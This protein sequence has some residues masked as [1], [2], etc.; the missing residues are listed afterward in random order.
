V[1]YDTEALIQ[2]AVDNLKN[3]TPEIEDAQIEIQKREVTLETTGLEAKLVTAKRVAL[4]ASDFPLPDAI[5]YLQAKTQLSRTTLMGILQRSGRLPDLPRNPQQFL[6]NAV[7]A[8]NM[9]KNELIVEGIQ[10]L[11]LEGAGAVWDMTLFESEVINGYSDRMVEVKNGLY[12]AV[13]VDSTTERR[14]AEGLDS[15]AD[16]P[17]FFK[18]PRW[19]KIE[20]PLGTYNPDWAIVKRLD[21]DAPSAFLV[22]ETKS[23]L[24]AFSL[25]NTEQSKIKCGERHFALTPEVDYKTATDPADI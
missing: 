12:D 16:I 6:D 15:R 3:K 5:A 23:T 7:R 4:E 2:K 1:E 19:F 24:D 14:F 18:L 20:T 9:A 13:E 21:A 8:V 22:R 11:P 10:Y 25:R 17:L